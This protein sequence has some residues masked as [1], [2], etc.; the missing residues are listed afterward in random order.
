M[1]T[2]ITSKLRQLK[3]LILDVHGVWLSAREVRLVTPDGAVS[4]LKERNLHDGQG[5]SF[6]RGLGLKVLFASRSEEPLVSIIKKINQLPS[7]ASG[8]WAPVDY[9]TGPL[10]KD[11][12]VASAEAWLLK[13]QLKWD[14]VGYIGDDRTDV[15]V[16]R[17]AAIKIVPHDAC[18]IVKK[19]A[20]IVL[21][22]NGGDGAV[23]E[24]SELLLDA[25]GIDEITL[26]AA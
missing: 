16:M 6:I 24:F 11:S 8:S 22:N 12:A 13:H 15:E 1:H 26:P 23:R 7:V 17:N 2:D 3:G 5:L 10:E 20:D 14:V 9:F 19:M 25:R 18:R 21:E 4:I